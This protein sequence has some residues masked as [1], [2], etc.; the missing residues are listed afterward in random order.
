MERIFE[1][2]VHLSRIKNHDEI[3]I[4]QRTLNIARTSRDQLYTE[5]Y[6]L[7]RRYRSLLADEFEDEEI[8]SLLTETLVEPNDV[9]TLFELFSVFKLI[10]VVRRTFDVELRPIQDTEEAIARMESETHRVEV[11]HDTQGN[12]AFSESMD[13]VEEPM[14]EYL[15]RYG[16]VLDEHVEAMKETIDREVGRNLFSGRPDMLVEVYDK[17]TEEEPL[18]ELL[19]GEMKYTNSEQTY[20]DG[21]KELLEYLKYAREDADDQEYLQDKGSV[22]RGVLVVDSVDFEQPS[23]EEV[24]VL[25]TEMLFG[26]PDLPG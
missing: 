4:N 9:P 5:A 19:I 20:S 12:L 15:R 10:R 6:D 22:L 11:F 3:N 17:R 1:R 24:S 2:N 25:D 14:P 23:N 7:L 21:F 8:R 13:D 16:E 26:D 18:S